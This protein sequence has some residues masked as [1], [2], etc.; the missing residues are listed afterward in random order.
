MRFIADLTPTT[1]LRIVFLMRGLSLAAIVIVTAFVQ[2]VLGIA[3]PVAP[4]A[5]VFLLMLLWNALIYWRLH[6]PWLATRIEIGL[7]LL[8]D[9]L[10]LSFLLYW[11]GGATNPFVS[12]FLIPVAVSAAALSMPYILFIAGLCITMYTFLVYYFQP[13]PAVGNR[14]GGDFHLHVLGMWVNFVISTVLMVVIVAGIVN[15][16]RSRDRVS[17][18]AREEL[19]Q[20]ERLVT[21]GTLAAGTAHE[22]NTPLSTMRM[23]LGELRHLYPDDQ[24]LGTNLKLMDDQISVCKEKIMRLRAAA[25]DESRSGGV[26]DLETFLRN[27]IANWRVA[28]PE[29]NCDLVVDGSTDGRRVCTHPVISQ[30][31]TNL[32]N[33][34]ADASIDN[35]FDCVAVAARVTAQ[36]LEVCIDDEGRGLTAAQNEQAGKIFFSSKNEG[37]GVG[38][39]LSHASL[40]RFGGEVTLNDRPDGGTRAVVTIPLDSLSASQRGEDG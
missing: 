20:H 21:M 37:V 4:V 28:R 29:I 8:L 24:T 5:A 33:N 16:L 40:G 2:L 7:N 18:Q 30:A 35:G 38:L 25:D 39:I 32:L 1:V 27:T 36:R 22:I 15:S 31:L 23:V 34:A 26:S 17:S 3:V 19:L 12:L 11:T 14:F 10:T 6:Q 13:L 9:I